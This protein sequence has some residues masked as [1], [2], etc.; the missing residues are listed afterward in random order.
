MRVSM[1]SRAAE[2][3]VLPEPPPVAWMLATMRRTTSA[4]TQVPMAK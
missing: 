3:T 1:G 2:M 4:T